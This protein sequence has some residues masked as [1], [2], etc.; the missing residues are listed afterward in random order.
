MKIQMK[1]NLRIKLQ[2]N[3][4]RKNMKKQRQQK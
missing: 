2:Q 1:I 4:N 3:E